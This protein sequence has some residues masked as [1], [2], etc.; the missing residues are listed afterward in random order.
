MYS[1][2][3]NLHRSLFSFAVNNNIHMSEILN[4]F[5]F[6]TTMFF[7]VHTL[8]ETAQ[9]RS[10]QV[11]WFKPSYIQNSHSNQQKE[12]IKCTLHMLCYHLSL[13]LNIKK[14]IFF[15][16]SCFRFFFGSSA[17]THMSFFGTSFFTLEIFYPK[18]NHE[19]L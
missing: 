19:P 14:E 3:Q 17:N 5:Q 2:F 8:V 6:S 9:F 4:S 10:N 11:A 18:C 15:V 12:D 13:L 7:L 1:N 16:T